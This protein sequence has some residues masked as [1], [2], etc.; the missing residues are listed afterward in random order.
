[1]SRIK[2]IVI[3]FNL[4]LLLGYFGWTIAA[5]EKTLKEGQL[6]LLELAPV[7][8]RS[9]MQGDYMQ[10]NYKVNDITG[11]KYLQKRGYCI[12][13]IDPQGVAQRIRFQKDLQ[14]LKTGEQAIKYF[15]KGDLHFLQIQLGAGS[16]FF[17]EGKGKK[18]EAA[19]FGGLKIDAAGN[20]VLTALYDADYKLI[21]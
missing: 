12:V 21:R 16:Y 15:S 17:E 11:L 19:K 9:L 5:K 13:R 6:V 4:L 10:L 18:F 20:S 14:P 2:G 1:M 7:D 3:V 8:P